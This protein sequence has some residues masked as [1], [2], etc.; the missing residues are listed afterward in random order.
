MNVKVVIIA[1]HINAAILTHA[2][3]VSSV[4]VSIFT[5]CSFALLS[6]SWQRRPRDWHCFW[7]WKPWGVLSYV[8]SGYALPT[9]RGFL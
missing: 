7:L 3:K 5:S 8:Q 2:S 1:C 6:V 9:E 4:V